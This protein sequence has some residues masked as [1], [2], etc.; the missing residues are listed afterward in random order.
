[1]VIPTEARHRRELHDNDPDAPPRPERRAAA[2]D[3]GHKL[4]IMTAEER[5]AAEMRAK[6]G[7]PFVAVRA[8]LALRFDTSRRY[9]LSKTVRET[10]ERGGVEPYKQTRRGLAGSGGGRFGPVS[11]PVEYRNTTLQAAGMWPFPVGAGAPLVGVPLGS[12]LYTHAPVCFDPLSW[13]T[14]AKFIGQPSMMLLGLPSFGKSSLA[15]MIML[16]L[17]ATGVTAL[18][19]G[20]M[21]PDYRKLVE[22]LEGGQVIELGAGLGT[23]NPLDLGPLAQIVPTLEAAI[24]QRRA[25]A[26]DALAD[27]D[28]PAAEKWHHSAE[29]ADRKLRQVLARITADRVRRVKGLLELTRGEAIQDYEEA[30]L[31]A[32]LRVCDEQARARGTE[33]LL[34]DLYD[35]LVTGPS[36]VRR[37]FDVADDDSGDDEYRL[38]SRALRRTLNALRDGGFGEVFDH[39]TSQPFDINAPAICID[40]SGIETS[41]RKLK[42]AVLLTCWEHGFAAIAAAHFLADAGCGPKR[43]F[44]AV[45]DEM[46]QVLRA[47]VGMVDRVDEL[48]RLN[49]NIGT[50]LLMCTHT[51][52]DLIA[53]PR[54]E[55]RVTAQGFIER[56]AALIV[57]ALPRKE[58]ARLAD[59][60]PFTDTEINDITSWSSPPALTGDSRSNNAPPGRGKFYIKVG[61]QGSP[62]IPLR[63][64]FSQSEIESGIHDTNH[65]FDMTQEWA[66]LQAQ[67]GESSPFDAAA[68][69]LA[70]AG[71]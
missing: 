2:R 52:S 20:D 62:G 27:G 64:I 38:E 21:R 57:G 22:T 10:A 11:K 61:E 19:L 13:M 31:R 45:L 5:F 12:H 18:V 9:N 4:P 68:P 50:A 30:A 25:A 70:G 35:V 53:L 56:A 65:R 59:I 63:T 40:V 66:Q 16:G 7:N 23:L 49:R 55:D 6:S 47:G 54:E 26:E 69:A 43:N 28:A 37:A 17:I 67:A 51:V 15:R 39:A 71:S 32:A 3:G 33:P 29:V 58:M 42:G 60:K 41:D 36:A 1:M 44:L 46:W 34:V 14:R 8:R 24:A 48:T